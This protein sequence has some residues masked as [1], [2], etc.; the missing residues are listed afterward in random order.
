[1]RLL[2]LAVLTALLLLSAPAL[3]AFDPVYEAHN[4]GKGNERAQVDYTP[5]FN[6]LLAR[7]GAE[8]EVAAAS[9]LAGDGPLRPFGRNFA[10]QLCWQKMNGCAGDVRLYDWASNGYGRVSP[11]LF[12]QRNGSTLS[13]HVWWTEHGPARRPGVVITNGSVQAPEELYW[14]GAQTLAKAGYVVLTW[15]PQGQGYS[16]TFGDGVDRNDGVPS[17][18]GGPFYDGTEDALDFFFSSPERPYVPRPSCSTGTSHAD[19]QAARVSDGRSSAYN[20]LYGLLDPSRVGIVGQSLGAGAVSYV[21]QRDDRVKTIVA[22]DNLRAPDSGSVPACASAPD[23]RKPVAPRVPALGIAGDYPLGGTPKTSEPARSEK[24]AAFDAL[25]KQGLDAGEI[26]IRGGG[27]FEYAYIPN[28]AFQATARGMDLV[29]W[30]TTA[31]MDRY[32]KGDP[33]AGARLATDRWRDDDPEKAIDPTD[34]N[35]FSTYYDSPIVTGGFT[36]ADLRRCAGVAPDGLP[37]PYSFLSDATSKD[38]PR[39]AGA[40]DTLAP[41]GSTG[42]PPAATA[43]SRARGG[44]CRDARAPRSQ[45]TRASR[46]SIRG[47]AADR[48]CGKA[49]G[50]VVAVSVAVAR[51]TGRRCRFLQANGRF[52]GR[53]SCLRSSY[54]QASGTTRWR[55]RLRHRLPPGRYKLWSRGV[56]A[57]GNTERKSRTKNFRALRVRRR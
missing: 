29:A 23:T 3:A 17:Q 40:N 46:T 20:P 33:S 21:G 31:W 43:G 57:T 1:M 12:T 7:R 16:D 28:P 51:V 26:V 49:S 55:L 27:H 2:T 47:R 24:H 22:W 41:A 34:S 25:R 37:K 38:A 36:C 9:I 45:I 10:G 50:R 56:D 4:F 48:G 44:A 53:R 52:S 8:N 39:P 15:E 54:L 35:L 11:V 18:A 13:G 32:V 42:A 6:V 30:Y 5:E 14:F 19:K